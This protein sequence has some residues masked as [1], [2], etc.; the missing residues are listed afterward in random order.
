MIVLLNWISAAGSRMCATTKAALSTVF[1]TKG[2]GVGVLQAVF[3]RNLS[4]IER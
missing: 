4:G 3:E 1:L 2:Q